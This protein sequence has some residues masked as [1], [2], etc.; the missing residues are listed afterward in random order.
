MNKRRKGGEDLAIEEATATSDGAG[1]E[2]DRDTEHSWMWATGKVGVWPTRPPV[3][4]AEEMRGVEQ[5]D[6]V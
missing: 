2:G 6:M 1:R 3:D 5:S 4:S